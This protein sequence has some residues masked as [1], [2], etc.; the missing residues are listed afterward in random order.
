MVCSLNESQK[1]IVE[2]MSLTQQT[3]PEKW[4]RVL[5]RKPLA[6]KCSICKARKDLMEHH[7][8][9]VPNEI[10]I[11]VCRKCHT[12]IHLYTLTKSWSFRPRPWLHRR[13]PK[14]DT[15]LLPEIPDPAE[16]FLKRQRERNYAILDRLKHNQTYV[17]TIRRA[18][19]VYRLYFYCNEPVKVIEEK[20]HTE[21]SRY[22][23]IASSFLFDHNI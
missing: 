23:R 11:T 1:R 21:A 22:L 18:C 2:Q 9:Y 8:Q 12:Y 14:F 20:A 17:D 15:W 4:A 7:T 5:P 19:A 13:Q 16:E 10:T 6:H 3:I